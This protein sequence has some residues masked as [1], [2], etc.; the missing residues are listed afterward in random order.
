MNFIVFTNALFN[1]N[2][3]LYCYEDKADI[4]TQTF[5]DV[6]GYSTPITYCMLAVTWRKPGRFGGKNLFT[7]PFINFRFVAFLFFCLAKFSM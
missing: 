5:Y 2:Q 4:T 1:G 6:V 3:T 7:N